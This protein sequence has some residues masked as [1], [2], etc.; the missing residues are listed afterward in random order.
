MHYAKLLKIMSLLTLAMVLLASCGSGQTS[1]APSRAEQSPSAQKQEEIPAVDQNE[2]FEASKPSED[3]E[4]FLASYIGNTVG[5]AVRDFGDEYVMD[6]Y[7]GSTIITYPDDFGFLFGTTVDTIT[8]DLVIRQ[9]VA[10]GQHPVVYDL[11]GSMTYSEIVETVG[12]ETNVPPQDRFFNEIYQEWETVL[13]F[14][15]REY[16]LIYF[17]EDGAENSQAYLY[18]LLSW[19]SIR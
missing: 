18:K 5:D 4:L 2:V 13:E 17:G 14:T 19:T 10:V 1:P 9:V 3:E 7:E 8:D 6:Y 16:R 11:T 12:G 15:Y